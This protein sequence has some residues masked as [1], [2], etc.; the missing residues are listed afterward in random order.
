MERR[1]IMRLI[2]SVILTAIV[3]WSGPIYD[4]QKIG[5]DGKQGFG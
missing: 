3:N 2:D 5:L 1:M 4:I